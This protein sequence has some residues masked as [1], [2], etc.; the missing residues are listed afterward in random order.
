MDI[1]G[2][3]FFKGH[4]LWFL[5]V[6][7]ALANFIG[8]IV[9]P[10][11]SGIYHIYFGLC[12]FFLVWDLYVEGHSLGSAIL[13]MLLGLVLLPAYLIRYRR[14]HGLHMWGPVLAW[15]VLFILYLAAVSIV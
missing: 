3:R 9:V 11:L 13:P 7:P 2:A 14:G 10:E 5:A 6:I 8:A 4:S 15:T 1:L 12:S